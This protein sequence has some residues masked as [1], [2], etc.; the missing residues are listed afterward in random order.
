M[1]TAWEGQSDDDYPC[2]PRLYRLLRVFL[3][4]RAPAEGFEVFLVW[5]GY[6]GKVR[7]WERRIRIVKSRRST[8]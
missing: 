7:Q 5:I 6:A 4:P 8:M 1:L 3:G 2:N